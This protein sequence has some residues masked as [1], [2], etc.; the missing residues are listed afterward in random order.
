MTAGP[1]IAQGSVQAQDFYILDANFPSGAGPH[2]LICTQTTGDRLIG[3]WVQ[4]NGA[5][6]AAPEDTDSIAEAASVNAGS[7]T[8]TVS[9]GAFFAFNLALSVNRQSTAVATSPAAM[10][11]NHNN[12]AGTVK[13]QSTAKNENLAAGNRTTEITW[14][15]TAV[16]YAATAMA[17]VPVSGWRPLLW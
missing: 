12:T 2:T 9:Q 11:S 8:L 17:F 15:G 7:L 13:T 3:N 5:T 6:Q 10:M 4:I 16:G 1:N 14:G